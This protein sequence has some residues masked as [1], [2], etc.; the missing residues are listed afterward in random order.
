MTRG[1]GRGQVWEII[2]A[3][4]DLD[5]PTQR[6][7][8]SLVRCDARRKACLEPLRADCRAG[9]WASQLP[10]V[11]FRAEAQARERSLVAEFLEGTAGSAPRAGAAVQMAGAWQ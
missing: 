2:D 7:M 4:Q 10:P 5:L 1:W 3:D 11:S 9:G 8:L 6:R